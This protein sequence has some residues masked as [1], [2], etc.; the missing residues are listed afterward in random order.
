M[1]MTALMVPDSG[2]ILLLLSG[3]F[4][5]VLGTTHFIYP[6]LFQYRSLIYSDSNL[7]K[8]LEPLRLWFI[9]YPL[10]LD[11]VYALI[12]LTNSHVSFV[13]VSIAAVEL[14]YPAWLLQD[15]RYL[16]RAGLQLSLGRTPRDWF[17]LAAF[18]SLAGGHLCAGL[19]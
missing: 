6:R 5:A 12:W 13:L 9:F 11:N 19:G 16:L 7:G 4:T 18:G 8:R 15:G 10:N 1:M 3:M 14:I 17:W 2:A